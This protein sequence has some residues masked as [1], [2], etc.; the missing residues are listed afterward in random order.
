[1]AR[2]QRIE[3][4]FERKASI[5]VG[6]CFL[7]LTST[8]VQH[9]DI[10]LAVGR[11]RAVHLSADDDLLALAID[12]LVGLHR[13]SEG[14]RHLHGELFG[15]VVCID[16]FAN[17]A[18]AI[19]RGIVDTLLYLVGQGDGTGQNLT[20]AYGDV[21]RGVG[22]GDGIVLV[23]LIEHHRRVGGQRIGT[24]VDHGDTERQA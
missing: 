13:G 14:R 7:H 3:L 1:M 21:L 12:L 20:A 23:F 17:R 5:V 15:G 6:G 8:V 2:L 11:A 9:V 19:D 22:G 18:R 16:E 4:P 24:I 10:Y